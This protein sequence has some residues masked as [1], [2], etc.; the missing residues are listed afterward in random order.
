MGCNKCT[1]AN[2]YE[3]IDN[4]FIAGIKPLKNYPI[5]AYPAAGH[6]RSYRRF[7]LFIDHIDAFAQIGRL[8][9]NLG[10]EENAVALPCDYTCAYKLPRQQA[11]VTVIEGGA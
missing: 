2:F 3:V 7:I 11:L 1:G 9:C 10:H 6:N 4:D 5:L 8:N